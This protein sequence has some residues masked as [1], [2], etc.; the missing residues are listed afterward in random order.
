MTSTMSKLSERIVCKKMMEFVDINIIVSI[1]Q[2]G[3]ISM[4]STT[5]NLLCCVN[6]WKDMFDIS[7]KYNQE[8]DVDIIYLDIICRYHIF[9]SSGYFMV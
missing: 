7:V 8:N 9:S 5:T 1:S 3:F 4:K 6:D 2:H